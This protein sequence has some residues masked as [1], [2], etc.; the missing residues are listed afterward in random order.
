MHKNPVV[1]KKYR[2]MEVRWLLRPQPHVLCILNIPLSAAHQH[3]LWFYRTPFSVH[4]SNQF[5]RQ[6]PSK[7]LNA[8]AR[9][10][11]P[12]LAF[13]NGAPSQFAASSFYLL[14]DERV[15]NGSLGSPF[16][17]ERM[18]SDQSTDWAQDSPDSPP[19]T[20]AGRFRGWVPIPYL[21]PRSLPPPSSSLLLPLCNTNPVIFHSAVKTAVLMEGSGREITN[22]E[23][24][25]GNTKV[26]RRPTGVAEVYA[27]RS[28]SLRI[29]LCQ[30]QG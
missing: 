3:S 14:P 16:L 15:P 29:L 19:S 27:R 10:I 13:V 20:S 6:I 5:F 17:Q 22:T 26:F 18:S 24:Q 21:P 9:G 25:T 7:M 1:L 28:A 23:E 2:S 30:Y 11:T 12:W 8:W 4:K